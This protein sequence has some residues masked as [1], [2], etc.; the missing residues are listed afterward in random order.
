M[1]GAPASA[2]ARSAALMASGHSAGFV[3]TVTARI[4]NASQV[5]LGRTECTG[6][7]LSEVDGQQWSR[8]PR[9]HVGIWALKG[10]R[11]SPVELPAA[12]TALVGWHS[13]WAGMVGLFKLVTICNLTHKLVVFSL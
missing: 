9:R 7:Y 4:S 6:E 13:R 3:K 11:P 8:R 1:L 5:P 10:L 2:N 12:V